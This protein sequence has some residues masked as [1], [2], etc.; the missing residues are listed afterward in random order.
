MTIHRRLTYA[1]LIANS[2]IWGSAF[3]IIK[4]AFSLITP[5]A[6]LYFRFLVA[7]ICALPIFLYY[8]F[9]LHPKPS[10]MI[11]VFMLELFG[12]VLPLLLLYE[13][14]ARTSA[15]AASLIGATG[16][17]FVVLGG[18]IFLHERE[19][20]REWQGI[21]LALLGSFV[22]VAE[23]L[24][25]GKATDTANPAYGNLL[26]MGS[27][28]IWMIYALIAKKFYKKHPPLYFGAATYLGTAAIY[29]M[30][31]TIRGQLPPLD[32]LYSNF[33]VLLPVL[34]MAIPGGILSFALYLYAQSKIEVSEA[35]LFTYLNG[36]VAIP[37][38]Y[39]ILGEK[40]SFLVILAIFV[41][42]YGV[43][44]SE[45]RKK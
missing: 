41:I 6:Y 33:S 38:T 45:T 40:P 15:L 22:I 10:Y 3:P 43:Y 26:I 8:L 37:A 17:I 42:T 5:M 36:A 2:I 25:L 23:P 44:R 31:L 7:G 12:T 39:F 14:L 4:P 32:I 20:K 21:A 30:L 34:Y 16:P 13:G 27:K 1:A 11:K 18:I 28:L 19:S 35:N 9:K 24:L 29:G